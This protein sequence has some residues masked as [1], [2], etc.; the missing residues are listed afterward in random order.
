MLKPNLFV[1]GAPKC[2][3]TS[4]V[5]WLGQHPE[6]FVSP[7]KEPHFFYTPHRRKPI[8]QARYHD[9]FKGATGAH[10]YLAEASVWYLFSRQ[11]APRILAYNPKARFIV[12]LRNPVDMFPSLHAQQVFAG[13][14]G[15]KDMEKAW[16]LSDARLAGGFRGIRKIKGRGDPTHMAYQHSCLLGQQVQTLLGQVPRRQIKFLLIEDMR[17]NAAGTLRGICDFLSIEDRSRS[18]DFVV[19]NTAQKPRSRK[20]NKRLEW[21]ERNRLLPR[22]ALD[23]LFRANA[24]TAEKPKLREA[25]K[26]ELRDHFR[27]DTQLLQDLIDR[28]LSAWL[29]A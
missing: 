27:H 25:F 9:Y 11:A 23:A 26:T 12:C 6:I 15:E 29:N 19:L 21:L 13:L 16:N 22:S 14:E 20:I 7:K 8:S 28:D 10:R 24:G 3:T 2:G 4:L 17:D 1:L 5:S 18:T